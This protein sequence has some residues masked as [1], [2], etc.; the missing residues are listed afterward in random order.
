MGT[1]SGPALGQP[2]RYALVGLFNTALDWALYGLGVA[3]LPGLPDY[4][5][6]GAS[7]LA[8]VLSSFCLNALWTFQ[9]Q[10]QQVGKS[11]RSRLLVIARFFAVSLVCLAL[12]TATFALVFQGLGWGRPAALAI[13]TGATFVCGFWLNRAWTFGSIDG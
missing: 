7:F 4:Q 6:K 9:K 5:I 2:V 13:A 1:Q 3:W 12:N 8:G 11:R 10:Y